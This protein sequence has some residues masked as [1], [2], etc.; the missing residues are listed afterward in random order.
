M[1]RSATIDMTHGPLLGKILLFSLP[2]MASNILQLLFNAA[3]IVVVG[4]F[5]GSASLAA[6]SSTVS[7]INL[8]TQLLIG[9]SV[10]VNVVIARYL[11]LGGQGKEISRTLHTAV[12][13]AMV[14]CV[15]LG[16]V[17]I[18]SSGWVL[19]LTGVPDDVRPLALVYMRIYFI[20]TPF[21]MLY[22]YGAAALRAAGDTRRPL[23]FLLI[24]GMVNVVLN[25]ISV[26]AL[27]MDVVGVAL[28]TVI[29]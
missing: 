9:L 11:G 4:R 16:A 28:A 13:V 3:D 1:K 25:L 21:T 22:N 2:L 14:G 8:F 10:G 12:L 27:H 6:V 20:G 19:D 15:A 17:G 5:A 26:I 24:S 29:S 23:F 18:L 7:V